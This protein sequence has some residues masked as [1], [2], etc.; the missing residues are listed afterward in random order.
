MHYL[1]EPLTPPPVPSDPLFAP[2]SDFQ[3][4]FDKL[5]ALEAA[6]PPVSEANSAVLDIPETS[7]PERI[8][9]S[10][11][12]YVRQRDRSEWECVKNTLVSMHPE[13]S[14]KRMFRFSHCS[15]KAWFYKHK[16]TSEVAVFSSA[17]RDRFCPVCASRRSYEVSQKVSEWIR[18]RRDVRFATFTLRS[19]DH[20]L[21]AQITALYSA[22]SR[23][24]RNKEVR[25][26]LRAGVWFFQT[27]F[28][29]DTGQ[30][31]PHLHCVTCGTY[32]SHARLSEAW[33]AASGD[34]YVVDIRYVHDVEKVAAYVARYAARPYRLLDCPAEKRPELLRG[35]KSR[36]L[37]G[38]WGKNSCRP[39]IKRDRVS[40][41]DWECIGSYSLVKALQKVDWRAT[42][43]FDAWARRVPLQ[44]DI[45]CYVWDHA[46]TWEY[47]REIVIPPPPPESWG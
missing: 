5:S 17:C 43:I 14:D 23:L 21:D 20:G 8:V 2:R 35:F 42:A 12:D 25:D 33:L 10:F 6:D 38:T 24:R 31:H 15:E 41:D 45:S 27:T 30:W 29:H 3:S 16:T 28:N 18:D 11:H 32:I 36:R 22:F 34:S 19:S 13:I 39:R 7:L 4:F 40:R 37:F 26:A 44:P 1:N 47:V 9:P 46:L